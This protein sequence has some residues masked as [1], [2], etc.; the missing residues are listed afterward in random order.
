MSKILFTASSGGHLSELTQLKKIILNNTSFLLTEKSEE[1]SDSYIYQRVF[2]TNPINR[3]EKLFII[4]FIKLFFK[5]MILYLKVKPDI[6]ISTG[7]LATVPICLISKMFNKKI[8]YIESFA[9]IYDPSL[10]GKIMYRFADVFIIQ[11]KELKKF[12]PKA[13]YFGGI[14]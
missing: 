10:T 14:F 4:K 12:Y 1:L 11:W 9:R 13:K 6:V 3:K 8:I 7:A 5:S 2:Y